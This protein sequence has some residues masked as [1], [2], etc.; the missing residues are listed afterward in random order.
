MNHNAAK[1]AAMLVKTL[2][3]IP[4]VVPVKCTMLFAQIAEKNAKFLSSREMI[5]RYTAANALQLADH[6]S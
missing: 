4:M 2:E 1:L 3:A 5:A 6:N